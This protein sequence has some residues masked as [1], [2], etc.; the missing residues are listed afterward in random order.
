L[1]AAPVLEDLGVLH[2]VVERPHQAMEV[3]RP[4]DLALDDLLVLEVPEAQ[5][6][7]EEQEVLEAQAEPESSLVGSGATPDVL[8]QALDSGGEEEA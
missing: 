2:P 1:A 4:R 6:E 3:L 7:W 8:D 5:E